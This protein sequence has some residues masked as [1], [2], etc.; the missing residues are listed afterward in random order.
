MRTPK[1]TSQA[2]VSYT[3]KTGDYVML[4]AFVKGW[5]GTD[6]MSVSKW[7][8]SLPGPMRDEAY[9]QI[10]LEL[11]RVGDSESAHKMAASISD[12]AIRSRFTP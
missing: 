9:L 5:F 3:E 10:A 4:G 12:E 8:S 11:R 1:A 6:S 7:A 2:I